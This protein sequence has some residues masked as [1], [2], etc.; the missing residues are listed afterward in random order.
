MLAAQEPMELSKAVSLAALPGL[1]IALSSIIVRQC[2]DTEVLR[3][4]PGVPIQLRQTDKD[5]TD[6]ELPDVDDDVYTQFY[7]GDL[8]REYAIADEYIGDTLYHFGLNG[9]DGGM[10]THWHCKRCDFHYCV[11]DK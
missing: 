11:T 1:G 4:K 6:I 2:G 3:S 10:G 5:G 8:D 9:P 7:I